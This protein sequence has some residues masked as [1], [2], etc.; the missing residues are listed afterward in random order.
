M[1]QVRHQV[2]QGVHH[3]IILVYGLAGLRVAVIELGLLQDV[4]L[5]IDVKA[6]EDKLLS[7]I[8]MPEPQPLTRGGGRRSG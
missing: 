7:D 3:M 4:R 5:E 6:V 8:R 2:A 1:V